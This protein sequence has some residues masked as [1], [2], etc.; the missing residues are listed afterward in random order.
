MFSPSGR[1][2]HFAGK[3][4]IEDVIARFANLSDHE[5]AKSQCLKWCDSHNVPPKIAN[6]EMLMRAAKRLKQETYMAIQLSSCSRVTNL[7]TLQ[8]EIQRTQVQ[9]QDMESRLRIYEGDLKCVNSV[10]Q[11]ETLEQHLQTALETVRIR[12]QAMEGSHL[13]PFDAARAQAIYGM[14]QAQAGG[15]LQHAPH[16]VVQQWLTALRDSQVASTQNVSEHPGP[17]LS[18]RD[19]Q[20]GGECSSASSSLY[21]R[22]L[23]QVTDMQ[24]AGP[25]Q[26][27]QPNAQQTLSQFRLGQLYQVDPQTMQAV[28]DDKEDMDCR[29]HSYITTK[30]VDRAHPTQQELDV[31]AGSTVVSSSSEWQSAFQSVHPPTSM[32][33]TSSGLLNSMALSQHAVMGMMLGRQR[34]EQQGLMPFELANVQETQVEPSGSRPM[35]TDEE[36]TSLQI[37]ENHNVLSLATSF[38]GSTYNG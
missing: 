33:S 11:L 23:C 26:S 22:A 6:A 29:E 31:N 8:Y 2:N 25:S 38:D 15:M 30:A 3:K 28:K 37:A 1:L 9:L 7:E 32:A 24:G 35:L 17:I 36:P 21:P 27:D 18:L 5:R 34:H 13:V 4:R 10:Q 14:M 19:S 16:H 12:K 20:G